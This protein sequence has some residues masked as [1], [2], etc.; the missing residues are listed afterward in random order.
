MQYIYVFVV[1][2][3]IFIFNTLYWSTSHININADLRV[4]DAIDLATHDASLQV[5]QVQLKNGN[6]VFDQTRV[7]AVFRQS[8]SKNLYLDAGFNPLGNNILKQPIILKF[9]IGVDSGV[10]PMDY[11][12]PVPNVP[13]VHLYKPSVITIVEYKL[14][15]KTMNTINAPITVVGI[16]EYK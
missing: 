14:P 3:T 1:M 12:T 2:L 6:I 15:Y 4:K 13:I 10:F 8:F 7:D 9:L 16:H 11:A 5:D